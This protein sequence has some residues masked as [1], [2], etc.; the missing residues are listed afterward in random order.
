[1]S[2]APSPL[3][4]IIDGLRGQIAISLFVESGVAITLTDESHLF[5]FSDMSGGLIACVATEDAKPELIDLLLTPE[6]KA[7]DLPLGEVP[8]GDAKATLL[9]LK[10]LLK[11]T[12]T[13]PP[14]YAKASLQPGDARASLLE[15]KTLLRKNAVRVITTADSLTLQHLTLFF[16]R[17]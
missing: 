16:H 8:P 13:L 10:T 5:F 6:L 1:M 12:A 15:L 2:F 11:E 14:G 4:R 3:Q 7:L 9:E 17:P